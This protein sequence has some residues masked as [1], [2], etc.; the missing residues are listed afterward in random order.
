MLASYPRLIIQLRTVFH[1]Q[2][3]QWEIDNSGVLLLDKVV[4]HEPLVVED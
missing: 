3:L 1:F 2:T 4:L